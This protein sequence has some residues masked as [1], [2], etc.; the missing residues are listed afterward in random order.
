MGIGG[1]GFFGL[2]ADHLHRFR[3]QPHRRAGTVYGSV[4]PADDQHA[5]ALD[6]WEG[7]APLPGSA[8]VYLVHER[9]PMHH[10]LGL[11][12]RHVQ[13]K[14]DVGPGGQQH[15]IVVGHQFREG[16]LLTNAHPQPDIDPQGL[17]FFH[18]LLNEAARQPVGRDAHSQHP[19]G[20]VQRLVDGH[21]ISPPG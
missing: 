14:G 1:H 11:L 5:L 13:S 3:P 20:L 4:P 19:P 12:S 21:S 2:Q 18:S 8:S 10:P 15:G 9:E 6:L 16:N 7:T 17:H